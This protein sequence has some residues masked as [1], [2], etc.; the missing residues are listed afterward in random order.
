MLEFTRKLLKAARNLVLFLVT[1]EI[2]LQIAGFAGRALLSSDPSEPG[3]DG[4]IVIL[5]VG[6]SHTFGVAVDPEDSYP[7]QLQEA[8]SQRFP[9]ESFRVI[10]LGIPGINSAFVAN[11]LERQ[12]LQVRPTMVIVWVGINNLWNL[13]ETESRGDADLA[14]AIRRTL[15]R[16]KLFRIAAVSWHART[17]ENAPAR[18]NGSWGSVAEEGGGTSEWFW[19]FGDEEV[20]PV[21]AKDELAD[22]DV[23]GGL[24]FDH[25]RI[26]SMARALGTPVLFI[27]YPFTHRGIRETIAA[28][29]GRLGV[30]I[31]DSHQSM[32]RAIADGHDPGKL[33]V[34]AAGP[35]PTGLL[36]RYVVEDLMPL[37][38]RT[39]EAEGA[40][41]PSPSA[42]RP[43]VR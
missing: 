27:N 3:N 7:S 10:N 22:S 20:R 34:M 21:A 19:K 38:I 23:A 26:V 4:E 28:S 24:E 41:R 42:A 32:E 39:L 43:L 25:D 8:V 30:P 35:H 31:V 9:S 2:A 33:I 37:V 5:T 29:S 6:D 1:I 14:T 13:L 40:V 36:Y 16:S 18:L 11:R 17:L 15:L 12:I